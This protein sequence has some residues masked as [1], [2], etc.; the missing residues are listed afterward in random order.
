VPYARA[1]ARARAHVH[2]EICPKEEEKRCRSTR[3]RRESD[4]SASIRTRGR[5]Q[6]T[7]A[8]IARRRLNGGQR[9]CARAR[10]RRTIRKDRLS[11]VSV[12]RIARLFPLR[13][14]MRC[15]QHDTNINR[16]RNDPD[17]SPLVRGRSI[18]DRRGELSETREQTHFRGDRKSVSSSASSTAM[19]RVI[20]P[21]SSIYTGTNLLDLPSERR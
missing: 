9:C 21:L 2:V 12:S 17:F 16:H 6:P 20:A 1:R 15:K 14:N 10:A 8:T 7:A 18:L 3:V 11:L 19:E 5:S 4:A 13:V